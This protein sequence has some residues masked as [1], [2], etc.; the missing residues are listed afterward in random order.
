M[1]GSQPPRID[2]EFQRLV[3]HLKSLHNESTSLSD[4]LV[5]L[6]FDEPHTITKQQQQGGEQWSVFNE[7]R[8]VLRRLRD[9]PLFSLFLSTTGKISRFASYAVKEVQDNSARIILPNLVVIQP[10]TDLGFDALSRKIAVN[11]SWDLERLT[12][13]AHISSMGRPL[14]VTLLSR[15]SSLSFM[16]L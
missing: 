4:P 14:Y 15:H 12:T 2:L 16:R 7:L 8:Y 13:D 1:F 9:R 10:Y 6:A 5:I 3:K 11:G